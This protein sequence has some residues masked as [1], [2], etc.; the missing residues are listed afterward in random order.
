MDGRTG[1]TTFDA[2]EK[3]E[4]VAALGLSTHI[5]VMCWRSVLLVDET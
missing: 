2:T 1:P 3:I 5:S 4:E